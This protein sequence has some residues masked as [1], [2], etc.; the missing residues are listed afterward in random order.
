LDDLT[1]RVHGDEGMNRR[2]WLVPLAASALVVLLWLGK[3]GSSF[4]L[5]LL[6][7]LFQIR[8]AREPSSQVV[9]IAIDPRSLG[10]LGPFPLT[11]GH[12]CSAG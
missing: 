1:W 2:S 5:K 4:D 7:F 10:K 11:K 6:D 3:V 9:I 8:G 12:L